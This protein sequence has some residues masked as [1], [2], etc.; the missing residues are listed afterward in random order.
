MRA[1]I[2]ELRPAA[3]DELGLTAALEA[4]LERHRT[5]NDLEIIEV[6]AVST[7]GDAAA[8]LGAGIEA[9]VYRVVQEALTN[10]VKHAQAGTVRVHVRVEGQRLLAEVADDGRGFT[11][12][13]ATGGG[14]GLTGMRERVLLAGGELTIDSGEQGTTVVAS[15]PL[16]QPPASIGIAAASSPR[17]SA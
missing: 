1:I 2:T 8:A 14:F 4:L 11:I 5:I 15:L 13:G 10:V 6:L 17:L 3:L 7:D 9:T 16:A 12:E